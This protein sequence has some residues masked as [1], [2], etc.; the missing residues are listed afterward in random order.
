MKYIST[1]LLILALNFTCGAQDF[2]FLIGDNEQQFVLKKDEIDKLVSISSQQNKLQIKSSSGA[3]YS[4]IINSPKGSI[5]KDDQFILINESN[6]SEKLVQI[7]K[8]GKLVAQVKFAK[9]DEALADGTPDRDDDRDGDPV[10]TSKTF[11]EYF[12]ELFPI[13]HPTEFGFRVLNGTTS[14][15][16]GN[17]YIHIFLDQFGNN[18]FST[19]PQGI[20]NLQYVVHIFYQED[21][22][23]PD[24]EAYSINQLEGEFNDAIIFNNSSE[25]K[26]IDLKSARPWRH[27]EFLLS[28]STSNIKFEYV[29]SRTDGTK[30]SKE[31]LGTYTI[32]MAKV[33]HGSFDIGLLNTKLISPT[34]N[35]IETSPTSKVVKKTESSNRGIVTLM[36]SFYVS[37]VILFEKLIGRD[38]PQYKLSGRSFLDDHRFYERIYPTIGVGINEKVFNNLLF[39][40]NWEF[41][42]G[43]AFF[44]GRHYGKVNTFTIDLGNGTSMEF[45][46]TAITQAQFDLASNVA[47]K[48]NW[49]F[50][51]KLDAMIFKTLFGL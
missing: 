7:M 3:P 41:A 9:R 46:K 5:E 2:T 20:S 42:R 28:T 29:K 17:K 15:F 43:G 18:I 26:G 37:P 40:F 34:Y 36:A 22:I 51:L 44:I 30:I 48:T 27:K 4:V 50:G 12:A 39:G 1:I 23:S 21:P 25:I 38:I 47:W 35:L 8:E 49:A 24:N 33:Y 32:K 11:G 19:I 45:G 14:K 16:R 31:T 10:V 13:I 6:L